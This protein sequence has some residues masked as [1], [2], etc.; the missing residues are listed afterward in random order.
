MSVADSVFSSIFTNAND[1]YGDPLNKHLLKK[2]PRLA[3]STM[4]NISPEIQSRLGKE[5]YISSENNRQYSN[6]M[7]ALSR[8]NNGSNI[9]YKQMHTDKSKYYVNDKQY[10]SYIKQDNI[11]KLLQNVN[12]MTKD[13]QKEVKEFYKTFSKTL[14]Q[15]LESTQK[16]MNNSFLS[17]QEQEQFFKFIVSNIKNEKEKRRLIDIKTRHG[18]DTVVREI[19]KNRLS[20]DEVSR[21]QSILISLEYQRRAKEKEKENRMASL[22][23]QK[24]EIR[25]LESSL[26]IITQIVGIKNAQLAQDSYRIGKSVLNVVKLQQ[27]YNS[28][29]PGMGDVAQV[30]AAT[31]TAGYVGLAIAVYSIIKSKKEKENPM[32]DFLSKNFENIFLTLKSMSTQMHHRFDRIDTRINNLHIMAS[33]MLVN[34]SSDIVDINKQ[35]VNIEKLANE[36]SWSSYFSNKLAFEQFE[37]ILNSRYK[38]IL[39]DIKEGRTQEYSDREFLDAEGELYKH[40]LRNSSRNRTSYIDSIINSNEKILKSIA[41]PE[42]F[43]QSKTDFFHYLSQF[44]LFT[45]TNSLCDN[46]M[47]NDQESLVTLGHSSQTYID[48]VQSQIKRTN[49]LEILK[50]HKSGIVSHIRKLKSYLIQKNKDFSLILQ[51]KNTYTKIVNKYYEAGHGLKA[52]IQRIKEVFSRSKTNNSFSPYDI[53][54]GNIIGKS[55]LKDISSTKYEPIYASYKEPLFTNLSLGFPHESMK[56]TKLKISA[57]IKDKAPEKYRIAEALG[58]GKINYNWYVSGNE[59]YVPKLEEIIN[60]YKTNKTRQY[61]TTKGTHTF[62]KMGSYHVTV[63]LS[64]TPNNKDKLFSKLVRDI[65]KG[66]DVSTR[67]EERQNLRNSIKKYQSS[68]DVDNKKKLSS[69]LLQSQYIIWT[70][71]VKSTLSS[72]FT[73]MSESYDIENS[74][75]TFDK[76]WNKTAGL[77]EIKKLVNDTNFTNK[78][79]QDS[80]EIEIMDKELYT[81]NISSDLEYSLFISNPVSIENII[82]KHKVNLVKEFNSTIV[83]IFKLDVNN[84]LYKSGDNLSFQFKLLGKKAVEFELAYHNFLVYVNLGYRKELDNNDYLK[85]LL[86]AKSSSLVNLS[87]LS[88]HIQNNKYNNHFYSTLNN[89]M[90]IDRNNNPITDHGVLDDIDENFSKLL[91]EI[92]L[93]REGDKESFSLFHS[94]INKLESLEKLFLK[95]TLKKGL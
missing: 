33:D 45:K 80:Y 2:N 8:W 94:Q 74:S 3:L 65:F 64:F 26:Y 69:F 9:N 88:K 82:G 47:C 27:M 59:L 93:I 38:G 85:G 31:L 22:R 70:N 5:I 10:S 92:N 4:L 23:K 68:F 53:F 76:F 44:N 55:R 75:E 12:S 57:S 20:Q 30:G 51:D 49:N 81:Y 28:N 56:D 36:I 77:K 87:K 19:N 58:L 63:Y 17:K 89:S 13:G 24:L 91:I 95:T 46:H 72:N 18:L 50:R 61:V 16:M 73:N 32:G 79:T 62:E 83:R 48:Y 34:I 41:P 39:F 71:T 90:I 11:Y 54:S 40:I 86:Y 66:S 29:S 14:E 15:N 67:I 35:N 21:K 84:N 43:T 60:R 7:T 78:F 1:L 52:S 42:N 25:E 37:K 6:T